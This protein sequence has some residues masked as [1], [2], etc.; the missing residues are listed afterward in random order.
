MV[1]LFDD[2][3]KVNNWYALP[4]KHDSQTRLARAPVSA[5]FCTH[6]TLPMLDHP[7]IGHEETPT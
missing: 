6:P 5:P 4:G 3:L 1:Q 7:F 2:E